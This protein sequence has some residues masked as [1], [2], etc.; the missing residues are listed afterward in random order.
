MDFAS[1]PFDEH[2]SGAPHVI[3]AALALAEALRVGDLVTVTREGMIER[4]C[5]RVATIHT[6]PDGDVWAW[7]VDTRSPQRVLH[8]PVASL[9]PGCDVAKK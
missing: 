6:G 9:S 3:A 1:T 5:A 8:E 2:H 4:V 7:L